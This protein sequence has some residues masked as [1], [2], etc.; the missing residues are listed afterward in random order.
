MK[1]VLTG[2]G[3]DELFAGYNIFKEDKVR[4]FWARQPESVHRPG[5]LTRLYPYLDRDAQDG[6]EMWKAFFR[7]GLTETQEPFYSH[8]IRW[9]NTSWTE[10]FLLPD[11]LGTTQGEPDRDIL[12]ELP[13][14]WPQWRP[15]DK[16]QMLEIMTFMSPYL[17]CSQGD[18]VAMA[19]GVE[20]RYPFLDPEV[21]RLSWSLPGRR[22]L[23]G[24]RDKYVLRVAASRRLPADIT[25][26]PKRPY[27]APMS[28]VIFAE[29]APAYVAELLSEESLREFGVVDPRAAHLLVL[30]ARRR[31][32]RLS[33]E[34]EDMAIIG[35]LTLQLLVQSFMRDFPRHVADSEESL[36]RMAPSVLE[37]TL[38]VSSA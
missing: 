28:S 18:R 30:K 6:G 12:D 10:R 21:I 26:R 9:D 4:R 11:V 34:R 2:E 37:D 22:K 19:H 14:D 20:V 32:G 17:L 1:V 15:L 16:A 13:E 5:L 31:G 8:R 23:R 25:W 33:G 35:I 29:D 27:R 36:A 38:N 3:A 7:N 24:L